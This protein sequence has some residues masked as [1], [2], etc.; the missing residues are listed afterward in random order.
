MGVPTPH[1]L[2]LSRQYQTKHRI[3]MATML[4]NMLVFFVR[5]TVLMTRLLLPAVLYAVVRLIAVV[6]RGVELSASA[7]LANEERCVRET[8]GASDVG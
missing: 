4:F 6:V 7:W 5:S 1:R 3:S 2:A 8:S